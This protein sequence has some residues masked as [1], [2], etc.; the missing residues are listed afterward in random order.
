[1]FDGRDARAPSL[2][3][4]C[5]VL[6]L[7]PIVSRGASL[8]VKFRSDFNGNGRGFNARYETRT[9]PLLIHFL[10]SLKKYA[11]GFSTWFHFCNWI[12]LYFF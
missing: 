8:F 12:V 2:G 1:M 7:E 5:N 9:R 4:F 10:F 6:S 3:R 11:P